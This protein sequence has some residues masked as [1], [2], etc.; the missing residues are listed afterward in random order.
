M[1]GEKKEQEKQI[2][3]SPGPSTSVS[4]FNAAAVVAA[5]DDFFFLVVSLLPLMVDVHKISS[6]FSSYLIKYK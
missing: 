6:N 2:E 1:S 3:N 4:V 5:V